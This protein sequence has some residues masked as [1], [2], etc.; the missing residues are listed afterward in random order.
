M[1][2]L[3]VNNGDASA[4][5]LLK[6]IG[7][8]HTVKVIDWQTDSVGDDSSYDLIILSGGHNFP[9]VGNDKL[10][11]SEMD[12][13]VKTKKPLLGISYGCELI[14]FVFGGHLER[15]NDPQK[16]MVDVNVSIPDPLFGNSKHF[17]VYENHRWLITDVPSQLTALAYSSH[18]IEALRHVS[19]PIYGLQFNPEKC[20]DR[21]CGEKILSNYFEL[22]EK[23]R[24]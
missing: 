9:V 10:L 8:K 2:I 5:A 21:V 1:N 18:G 4:E 20:D 14:A 15:M 11:K 22:L 6:T 12:L 19:R 23:S 16:G 17:Q 3:L 13:I 24:A 7:D